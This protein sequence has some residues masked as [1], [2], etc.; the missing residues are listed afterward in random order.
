MI[1]LADRTVRIRMTEKNGLAPRYEVQEVCSATLAVVVLDAVLMSASFQ[2]LPDS[3]AT[4]PLTIGEQSEQSATLD[5]GAGTV[6]KVQFTP[7]K[8]DV[9]ASGEHALSI[10]SRGLLN[11]EHLRTKGENEPEGEWDETF[12]THAD[13]KPKGPTSGSFFGCSALPAIVLSLR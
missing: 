13:S 3:L 7:I 6:V 11:F 8:L 4:T 2:V 5:L 9:F 1:A 12:K 10:N